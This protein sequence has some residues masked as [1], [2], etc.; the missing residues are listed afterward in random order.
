MDSSAI[1]QAAKKLEQESKGKH[2]IGEVKQ[3]MMAALTGN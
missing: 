2:K 1:S 3:K